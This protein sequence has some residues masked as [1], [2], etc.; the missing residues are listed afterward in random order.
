LIELCYSGLDKLQLTERLTGQGGLLAHLGTSDLEQIEK[1]IEDGDK[2]AELV[3]E[4]MAQQIAMEVSSLIP[5]FLGEPV[6]QIILTGG[7]VNSRRLRSRLLDL[8]AQ[9][10]VPVT[11]RPGEDELEALRDGALRV[12][13]G[14]ESPMQYS[15]Q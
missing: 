3:F 15:S 10:Q 9:L 11:V 8:L 6:D 5:K 14:H 7:M 1:T 2:R 13:A 4:A 12:L